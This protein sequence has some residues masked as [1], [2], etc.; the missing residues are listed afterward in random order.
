LTLDPQGRVTSVE[1]LSGHEMLRPAAIDAVKQWKFRPVIRNGKPV[2]AYTDAMVS[3]ID[4]DHLSKTVD[5]MDLDMAGGIAAAARTAELAA[6]FPRSPDQVL[7]DA[8]Q[9]VNPA[10]RAAAV[11]A[12]AK[13]AFDAGALDKARAYAEET[14]Q[15]A[16]D[17]KD[18]N[19][20]NAIYDGNTVLGLVALRE[21]NVDQ[22][23][24]Y[25][26]KAAHTP[27]SPQ[28]NSFGPDLR[29]ARELAAKGERDA[30][31]E[32]VSLCR[33]FWK[34]GEDKLDALLKTP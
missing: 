4:Y 29:L 25:L 18:W 6:R 8:E 30:V 26:I 33:A 23:K 34:M 13:T 27:G 3:F 1:A 20:G 12:L 14:L 24:Q 5:A 10:N 17:P 22:A 28:L 7:A 32:Y 9:D 31:A 15:S 11:Q 16:T 2:D 19:Y 21:G